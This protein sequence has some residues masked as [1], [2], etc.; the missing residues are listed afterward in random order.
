MLFQSQDK[1]AFHIGAK[2]NE[3]EA[4]LEVKGIPIPKDLSKGPVENLESHPK[5]VAGPSI[6]A[7]L[8]SA[9]V[10]NSGSPTGPD[11][12][13]GPENESTIAPGPEKAPG[14]GYGSKEATGWSCAGVNY[15]LQC[16]V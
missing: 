8:N 10:P 13:A 11:N 12:V 9:P 6:S 14:P 15:D 16:E 3:V 4:I 1:L 2:H 5:A 7:P